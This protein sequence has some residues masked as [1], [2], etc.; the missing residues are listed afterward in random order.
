MSTLT[1]AKKDF[2]DGIRSRALFVVTGLFTMFTAVLTYFYIEYGATADGSSQA[3]AVIN[4]LSDP[5]SIFLPLLGTMLGY[6][7]VVG[8]RES[9]SLKF[10][11]G[12][13]YTRRDVVFGKLLG[14]ASIVAV[15][16]LVGI[17]IAGIIIAVR[18]GTL[19]IAAY[20]RFTG[21]MIVLGIV[22]VAVAIA[23]SAV[24]SSTTVATWGAVGLVILFTFLWDTVLLVVKGFV[25][26]DI[27]RSPPEW[28]FLFKRLN[29]RNAFD[30]ALGGASGP[31]PFYLEL[32]FGIVIFGVWLV[33][34][35]GLA[36][37]R[38]QREDLA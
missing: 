11:L 8:E 15:T 26:T 16:V 2:R 35:L 22:F 20:T 13:P 32:W 27:D 9:G 1:I 17:I 33:V 31:T 10:L 25:V 23:F 7:A 5:V 14:C 28:F 34:P 4:S 37:L 3:T 29:P 38:F 6:K 36:Y 19:P 30:A 18:V 21:T 12:L 24:T